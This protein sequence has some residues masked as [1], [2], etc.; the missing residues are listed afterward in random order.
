[1]VV[2]EATRKN[3]KQ[4]GFVEHK[5]VVQAIAANGTDEP[6]AV[7][8]LPGRLSSRRDFLDTH[9]VNASPEILVVNV[10]PIPEQEPGDF[11]IMPK[12]RPLRVTEQGHSPR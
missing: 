12:E 8:V 4:V 3:A 7:R 6:F 9:V 2:A 1:M 5:E 11:V 10:V